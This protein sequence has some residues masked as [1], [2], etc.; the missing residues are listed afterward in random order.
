MGEGRYALPV[1]AETYPSDGRAD[2]VAEVAGELRA[3][4]DLEVKPGPWPVRAEISSEPEAP[5]GEA[6]EP[7]LVRL[8]LFDA[9]D[10][11]VEGSV[12]DARVSSGKVS[13]VE[14]IGGGEYKLAVVPSG[15]DDEVE[16]S[17]EDDSGYFATEHVVE[18][19]HDV[20][21]FQVG[22]GGGVGWYSGLVPWFML[23]VRL[24]PRFL[25]Q[26]L[27]FY[28]SASFRQLSEDFPLPPELSTP[29]QDS[30]TGTLRMVP[31]SLGVSYD[32]VHARNWSLYAGGGGVIAGYSHRL[33]E[34]LF[35][36]PIERGVAPGAELLFGATF[37]GFFV[38]LNGTFI[39]ISTEAFEAPPFMV[40]L[41]IGYRA[42]TL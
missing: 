6:D 18:F 9:A 42:G 30:L 7:F 13:R 24:R 12:L 41:G 28:V 26:R 40:G 22:V 35:E 5:S 23:D 38:Q 11:P 17:L 16:V 25:K 15:S 21:L 14:E 32:L 39:P 36:T 20:S 27:A 34:A 31:I 3:R 29:E 37:H 4:A 33:D 2:L 10:Q 1:R 19:G 8:R